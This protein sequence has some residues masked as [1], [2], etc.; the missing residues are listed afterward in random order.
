MKTLIIGSGGREHAI[1]LKLY[2]ENNQNEIFISPGNGGTHQVGTNVSLKTHQEIVDFCKLKNIELVVIGPEQP[3]VDGLADFLR[4]NSILVFGPNKNAARIE[5]DKTFAKNLMK[6]YNIPTADFKSFSKDE[7]DEAVKYLQQSNFPIVIKASGLA[8]GKGVI[9]AQT[10]DEAK[11]AIDEI[12]NDAIFGE[13]GNNVVIEEFLEGEELSV[14]VVTD[15]EDYVILPPSQDHKRIGEGDTG[16]NT[17]GMGAYSPLNFVNA[18][19]ISE[20]EQ[21]IIIPTLKGLSDKKSKF[22]GCLYCGLIRTKDGIKVIEFNCRFGDPEIQVVLQL[23]DKSFYQLLKTTAEGQTD[24]NAVKYNGG[25][26][27]C[28]VAASGGYPDSYKKGYEITGLSENSEE[29]KIIH[30]GT[31]LSK[32]DGKINLLT[33]GG[34]VLN[35]VA[36]SKC[37]DLTICKKRAY[38]VLSKVDFNNIYFRK[39]IGIKG[40]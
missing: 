9:I 13:A 35:I 33:N 15:G 3:L 22:N 30:A 7:F 24:E 10:F 36:V 4:Q 18:E 26:A 40:T 11:N 23:L 6:E 39:D 21:N 31:I 12:M 1:A 2:E 38:K 27:I 25:S 5:G 14:F 16:K 20:I 32:N 29:I 37:N 28:V 8:A 19:L 17:G 34:R